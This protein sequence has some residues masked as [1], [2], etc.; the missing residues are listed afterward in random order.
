MSKNRQNDQYK[1]TLNSF[2]YYHFECYLP[3][4]TEKKL[5]FIHPGKS[6]LALYRCQERTCKE[7][8]LKWFKAVLHVY[9]AL[10]LWRYTG[11]YGWVRKVNRKINGTI[12]A[13]LGELL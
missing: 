12:R 5:C 3:L 13:A 8:V 10:A 1:Y 2:F 11:R 7:M 4:N 9:R 6:S